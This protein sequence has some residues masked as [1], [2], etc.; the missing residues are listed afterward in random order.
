M[1]GQ[2]VQVDEDGITLGQFLKLSGLAGTGAE[3]KDMIAK[4]VVTVGGEREVK[5]GRQ[6]VKGDV[7]IVGGRTAR[8]A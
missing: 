8:V 6:L 5:R 4:G 3:A 1:T 7:V 2:D